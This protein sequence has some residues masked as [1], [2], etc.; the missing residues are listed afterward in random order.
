MA[1]SAG[2]VSVAAN[3]NIRWTGGAATYTVLEL[4]R[5]LQDLADQAAAS[6]DDL[7]D[8]TSSTPSERS[9]DNIITL[10]G[11]FNIDDTMA[12]HLYDGS[13]SQGSGAILYSGL[14]VV[15]SVFGTTTLQIVQDNTLYKGDTP[16]W[17]TGLNA[18]A[19]QNILMRCL[20][21]TRTASADVDGKR[22]R[23]FAREWTH[24]YAEFS[25]TMGLGN[26]VAAIFTNSDLNNQT[27][28]GT[29][30]T[31]TTI[32]N[33][34]G[35]QTIDL[36]NGNGPQPYF[37]QWNRATY[38]INQL[39]ERAKY[40]TRR[41]T[42][43]TIHGMDG[44]LFRGITHQ[45]AFDNEGGSGTQY[46]EDE[47]LSW[48]TGITAGSAIL[49][50]LNDTG[51]AGTVWVQLTKGVPP[52]DNMV[53]TGATSNHT[54]Q[55][56]G[57]VTSR[58]LS[59]VFLGSSTGSAIIGA[60]GIGIESA[61]LTVNDKLT[62]L[63]NVLQQPPNNVSFTVTGL[64]YTPGTPDRVL[65]APASGG[66]ILY[67][68]MTLNGALG[69]GES[70]IT[71]Q[72]GTIPADTPSTGTIRV[73]STA[74]V[75]TRVTYTGHTTSSFTGCTGTPAASNGANVF[76]SYIDAAATATAMSVTVVYNADRD[77]F[78]RVRNGGAAPIKT[79]E[80][81]AQ[82]KSTNQSV[83]AIR[84]SDL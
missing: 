68:Q 18:D 7:V 50:A 84:T 65:V 71:V 79:F 14:V 13:I 40:I 72:T 64:Y 17:G 4:H 49:L 39:Y 6:G 58:S 73:L 56:Q 42:T 29:V 28:S 2:D 27:A 51:A 15:G 10:L 60:F 83:A 32:T 78:V 16:F 1:I 20:I 24:T 66:V 59:P 61:D 8:I 57:S 36:G 80:S 26:S 30:A 23:I 69:G 63:L 81:P 19:T 75:Y 55:V 47:I 46:T 37:S 70:T 48:G 62:D 11:A 25:V 34:E 52:T 3:G 35:Y 45:W 74:G 21:K 33:T 5:Y 82:I 41:G 67:S 76:I 53:V 43:E 54:A 38:T 31:W 77:L 9:T 22:I 12:E 44:E